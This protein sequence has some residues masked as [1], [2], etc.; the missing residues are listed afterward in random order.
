MFVFVAC[1]ARYFATVSHQMYSV[2]DILCKFLLQQTKQTTFSTSCCCCCCC[3]CDWRR[4]SSI[5]RKFE[6]CKHSKVHR[7]IL[8]W[9]IIWTFWPWCIL[10]I[11]PLGRVLL[12]FRLLY[13]NFVKMHVCCLPFAEF[14]R[15]SFYPNTSRM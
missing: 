8:E 11:H 13:S 12:G 9:R 15:Q 10:S 4:V 6:C 2:V 5:Q 7:Q 1:E 3:F 14:L